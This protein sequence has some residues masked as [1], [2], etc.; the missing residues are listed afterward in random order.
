A[1]R[2][3]ASWPYRR[4]RCRRCATET[5]TGARRRRPHR[6]WL[7]CRGALRWNADDAGD[8]MGR[9]DGK[10]AFITGA[11]RGQGRNHAV[12]LAEEG[13]DLIAV[14]LCRGVEDSTAPQR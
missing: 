5:V 6:R 11:A 1:A 10:V 7:V 12:R 4:R 2:H 8:V 14:D 13:A 9:V 3:A